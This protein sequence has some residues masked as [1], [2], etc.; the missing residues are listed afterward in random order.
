MATFLLPADFERLHQLVE[1][2]A[3][4]VA[5]GFPLGHEREDAIGAE[6]DVGVV[7]DLAH[8]G[9]DGFEAVV[10]DADDVDGGGHFDERPRL[11]MRE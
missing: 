5:C 11:R 6:E 9:R 2:G 4:D 7:D 3:D 8:V 1:V 10:A